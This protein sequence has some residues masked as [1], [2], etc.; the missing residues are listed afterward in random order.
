MTK[1]VVK[2]RREGRKKRGKVCA[3]GAWCTRGKVQII[4]M[5]ITKGPSV[6]QSRSQEG[7]RT[8]RS[9]GLGRRV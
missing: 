1:G 9:I 7:Q 6:P 2:E 8:G 4:I 3:E 5:P